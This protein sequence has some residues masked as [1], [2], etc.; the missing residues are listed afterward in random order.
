[1]FTCER[2]GVNSADG[3]I[4]PD[5]TWL[6]DPCAMLKDNVDQKSLSPVT[7]ARTTQG[8]IAAWR[9]CNGIQT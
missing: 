3:F 5:G 4:M 9:D 8:K 6:C 7:H 1:V 2:C